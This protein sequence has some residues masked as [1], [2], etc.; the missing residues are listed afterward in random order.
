MIDVGTNNTS[1][2]ED[3]F[4][5]GVRRNRIEGPEYF[6]LMDELMSAISSRFPRALIQFEVTTF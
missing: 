5:M 4:Y 1:L 6:E 2:L 3:P